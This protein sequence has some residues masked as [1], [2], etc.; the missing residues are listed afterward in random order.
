MPQ[1]TPRNNPQ[2]PIS[3]CHVLSSFADSGRKLAALALMDG[4][5]AARFGQSLAVLEGEPRVEGNVRFFGRKQGFSPRLLIRLRR[6]FAQTKPDVV[7]THGTLADFYGI[8]AAR[9]A[10]IR[11]VVATCHRGDFSQEKRFR[12][13][14]R[15]RF[16]FGLAK[17]I[18]CVSKHQ[19]NHMEKSYPFSPPKFAQ[20]YLGTELSEAWHLP[21]LKEQLPAIPIVLCTG[22]FRPERDHEMLLKAFRKLHEAFPSAEL[23]LAGSGEQARIGP[24]KRLAGELGIADAV[25]FL[26]FRTDIPYLLGSAWVFVHPAKWDALPRSVIEASASARPVI[27]TNVGGIP[28]I[29]VD[30]ETGVL[31]PPDDADAMAAA[32]HELLRHPDRARAMG[33]AGRAR[34]TQC[35]SL[36]QMIHSYEELYRQLLAEKDQ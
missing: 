28:E 21:A 7:H 35:F 16:L 18:V 27:A 11:T 19:M 3:V 34:V 6:H 4:L 8:L 29:V 14:I 31:V 25:R 32:L 22:H 30:R 33:L 17:T 9:L 15:N 24:L 2:S 10:G 36:N 5:D 20:I 12:S 26:G 23:H 1:E 13:R